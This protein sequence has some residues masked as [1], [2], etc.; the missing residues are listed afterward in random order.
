MPAAARSR[1]SR[2]ESTWDIYNYGQYINQF[3][4]NTI[5]VIRE[6]NALEVDK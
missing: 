5:K 1:Q 3:P 2:T 6:S 4:P